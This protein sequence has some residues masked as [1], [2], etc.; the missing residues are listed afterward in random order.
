MVGTSGLLT[1][2]RSRALAP[3]E[4]NVYGSYCESHDLRSIGA[5]CFRQWYATPPYV[6]LRWSEEVVSSKSRVLI[7]I[8]F[9][10]D[11]SHGCQIIDEV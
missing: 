1:R 7:N 11:G 8:M 9:L 6:S 4:P 3:E 2:S 5:R 10:R